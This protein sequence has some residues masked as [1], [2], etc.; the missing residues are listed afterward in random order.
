MLFATLA[1]HS[2]K[3][4]LAHPATNIRLLLLIFFVHMPSKKKKI[5]ENENPS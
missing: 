5:T 1:T 3:I 2:K 4:N